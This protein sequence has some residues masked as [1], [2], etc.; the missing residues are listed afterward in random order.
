MDARPARFA[1][2]WAGQSYLLAVFLYVLML[3]GLAKLLGIGVD[4]YGFR[5][6]HR[7]HLSNQKRRSW[8]W[9]EA[10]D[11]LLGLVLGAVAA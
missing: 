9:D 2:S 1:Y 6:E 5:V 11:W 7:F 3:T 8:L 4:Y 10:K